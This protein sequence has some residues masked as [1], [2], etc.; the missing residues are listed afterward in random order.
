MVLPLVSARKMRTLVV[1]QD[2]EQ[3]RFV[4]RSL[5]ALG[6][7]RTTTA[8][9][10]DELIALTH[11]SPSLAE[12]FDLLIVSASI[13]TKR[14]MYWFDF[15]LGNARLKH[16]L[17]SDSDKRSN[18]IERFTDRS[19]QHVWRV[20]DVNTHVLRTLIPCIDF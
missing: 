11:Y 8:S 2:I 13:F 3:R 16:V 6:Y 10:F 9:C 15:C 14:N 20:Q 7:Y 17:V 4:E 19:D 1:D 12:R 5:T 18:E